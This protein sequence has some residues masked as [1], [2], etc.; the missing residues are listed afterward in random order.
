MNTCV[1]QRSL[2]QSDIYQALDASRERFLDRL[3]QPFR[4]Q[5]ASM[6]A[7]MGQLDIINRRLITIENRLGVLHGSVRSVHNETAAAAHRAE[8]ERRTMLSQ[9][10]S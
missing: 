1:Q 8:P 10:F 7:M 3:G 5:Q 4:Q 9:M 2:T 6:S